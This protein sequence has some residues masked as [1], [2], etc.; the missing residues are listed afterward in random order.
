MT[1]PSKSNF[2]TNFSGTTS[3][4]DMLSSTSVN[5]SHNNTVT[6][7][8]MSGRYF[9]LGNLLIQFTTTTIPNNSDSKSTYDSTF[10]IAYDATPYMVLTTPLSSGGNTNVTVKSWNTSTV[11]I[12]PGVN[13]SIAMFM[14]IGPRPVSSY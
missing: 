1:T 12:S 11:T 14:V 8:T 2:K 4:I 13:D 7:I 9:Y 3:N 10:P 5:I 6:N